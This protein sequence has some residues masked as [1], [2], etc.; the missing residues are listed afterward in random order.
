MSPRSPCP[1]G[2]GRRYKACHG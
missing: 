1:C 2:S